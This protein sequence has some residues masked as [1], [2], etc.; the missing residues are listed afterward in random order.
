MHFKKNKY[1]AYIQSLSA[2][3]IKNEFSSEALQHDFLTKRLDK[4]VKKAFKHVPHY[5]NNYPE[6]VLEKFE[7]SKFEKL[8]ILDRAT[9]VSQQEH[10]LSQSPKL[11]NQKFR[12]TE[13]S[14]TSGPPAKV[15]IHVHARQWFAILWLR[16]A[17]WFRYDLSQRYAR[18]R[19][20]Q[21]LRQKSK[22]QL[23][24]MKETLKTPSWLVIGPYVKTGDEVQFSSQN[25]HKDIL[26]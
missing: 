2:N 25:S 15:H 24:G 1:R 22:R 3:L 20:P 9:L 12:V 7:L 4:F 8:P 23:L 13:T 14:G 5:Q 26:E 21:Q 11:K 10:L 17:R 19:L 16:Q 6:D 18:L